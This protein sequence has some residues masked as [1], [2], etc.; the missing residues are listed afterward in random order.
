MLLLL[1]FFVIYYIINHYFRHF[2]DSVVALFSHNSRK[3][4]KLISLM[5]IPHSPAV[6]CLNINM[7]GR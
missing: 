4:L 2:C 7:L 5:Y 6:S 1:I 3:S